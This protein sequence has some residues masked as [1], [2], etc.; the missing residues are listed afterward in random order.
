MSEEVLSQAE[1]AKR[2][3]ASLGRAAIAAAAWVACAAGPAGSGSHRLPGRQAAASISMP[4]AP[5]VTAPVR[6]V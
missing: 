6:S 4:R 3:A 1:V 2:L 5:V